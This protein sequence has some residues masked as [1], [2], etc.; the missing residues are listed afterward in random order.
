MRKGVFF[1]PFTIGTP[2]TAAQPPFQPQYV[3]VYVLFTNTSDFHPVCSE[4][5]FLCMHR[6]YVHIPDEQFNR[7]RNSRHVLSYFVC[8]PL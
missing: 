3:F 7:A 5:T 1:L 4:F 6:V 2:T 8:T